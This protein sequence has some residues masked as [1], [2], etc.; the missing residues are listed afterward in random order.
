MLLGLTVETDCESEE[1]GLGLLGEIYTQTRNDERTHYTLITR[2]CTGEWCRR[3]KTRTMLLA[4]AGWLA[5]LLARVCVCV[6][7]CT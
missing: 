4:L 5:A 6:C 2:R 3:I 7:A 1:S